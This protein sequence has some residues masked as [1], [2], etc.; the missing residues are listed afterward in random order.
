MS[1]PK[2]VEMRDPPGEDDAAVLACLLAAN[3]L[4]QDAVLAVEVRAGSAAGCRRSGLDASLNIGRDKRHALRAYDMGVHNI[5]VESRG[6]TRKRAQT[7]NFV[8]T[9][10][11]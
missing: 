6:D 8:S 11:V 5:P 4:R 2:T 9:R 10:A 7:Q 3:T 1:A